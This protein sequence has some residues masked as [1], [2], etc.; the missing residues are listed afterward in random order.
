MSVGGSVRPYRL[1]S[2]RCMAMNH[3][4]YIA[5]SHSTAQVVFDTW[6][7]ASSRPY[8]RN[9]IHPHGLYSER[10]RNGTQAVPYGFADT[11]YLCACCF[12]NAELGTLSLW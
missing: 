8:W 2:L 10:S 4:R 7:A 6:R 3:R 11:F 12:Y 5:W 1:Y 9:T